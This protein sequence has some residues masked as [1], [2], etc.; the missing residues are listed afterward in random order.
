MGGVSVC[1]CMSVFRKHVC[2]YV[3]VC[4]HLYINNVFMC[5]V[6]VH[7]CPTVCRVSY[8]NSIWCPP[9]GSH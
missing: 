7:A 1:V 5:I 4:V 2:V 6:C 3:H 8:C 9:S